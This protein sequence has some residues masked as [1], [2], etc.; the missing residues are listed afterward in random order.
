MTSAPGSSPGF[1]RAR[2]VRARPPRRLPRGPA[3][4]RPKL[5]Q[6]VVAEP[7]RRAASAKLGALRAPG[8]AIPAEQ[9]LLQ[10]LSFG[11]TEAELARLDEMGY[12]AYLD[13]QLNY[14]AIDDGWL[15]DALANA[16]PT[17]A[18]SPA[19]IFDAYFERRGVPIFELILASIF[20]AVYSP[21][22]LYE[23]MVV[24]W[25]DHFNIDLLSDLG[26]LLKPTDDR[27]VIR[28]HALGKFPDLLRAS[29]HSPAMLV[30]LTNDTNDKAHP[31]ENYARELMELHTMGADKGY[32][33]RDVKEV[34]RCFT[35]WTFRGRDAGPE[36]GRFLFAAARHDDGAKRVLG[37]SIPAGGGESDGER[38]IDILAGRR[39]TARFIGKKLLR[40]F[41]GYE[42]KNKAI[43]QVADAYMR[44]DGDIRAMLRVVLRR[45]RMAAAP[46]KLKRPFHL[47]ASGVRALMG[48][49]EN[50][51]YLL[52]WLSSVGHLPFA[53][54]APNGYPDSEGYWS[55]LM[56][57][58]W[59]HAADL[60]FAKKSG[61]R[62]DPSLI[63]PTLSAGRLVRLINNRLF[64]GALSESS[65]AGVLSFLEAKPIDKS[66]IRDAIGLALSA[67]EFQQY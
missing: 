54:P 13:E 6:A 15:E 67:P 52:A 3:S 21:R 61:V 18:M 48:E 22:Q 46:P 39:R 9:R 57:P 17:L 27:E 44:S 28:R 62:I 12:E 2:A 64:N 8:G 53:W 58:R 50:P 16:F 55:G 66:R 36:L 11:W 56:L 20:R 7:R 47:A 1:S 37:H 26:F 34:A 45:N 35:G 19:Q 41:W 23:R 29:A 4:R 30:Y 32:T 31:N 65:Q 60:P 59:N 51:R 43:D 63:D 40:Y 10:R 5:P 25:S 49:I 14:E 33:E 24:F 42:P 38:V